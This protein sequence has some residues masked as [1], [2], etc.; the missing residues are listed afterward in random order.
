MD[1]KTYKELSTILRRNYRLFA[2]VYTYKDW[3]EIME[4]FQT[5]KMSVELYDTS[6]LYGAWLVRQLRRVVRVQVEQGRVDKYLT[7]SSHNI[8]FKKV[9]RGRPLYNRRVYLAVKR[10]GGI[11]KIT[12]KVELP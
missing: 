5:Q 10:L 6:V 8:W 9:K 2:M 12:A 7:P 1:K 3:V 11:K 4:H